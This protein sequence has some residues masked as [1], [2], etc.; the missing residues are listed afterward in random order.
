LLGRHQ[1]AATA[2]TGIIPARSERNLASF[3]CVGH[4]GYLVRKFSENT[5]QALEVIFVDQ[6]T[7]LTT[8][9]KLSQFGTLKPSHLSPLL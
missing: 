4:S 8:E 6:S 7:S 3:Y 9:I 5:D 1:N 2:R